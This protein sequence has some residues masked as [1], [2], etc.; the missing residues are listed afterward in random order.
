MLAAARA[1]HGAGARFAVAAGDAE[2]MP[3][4]AGSVDLILANLLLPWCR[5]DRVFAEVARVLAPNGLLLFATLGPDTLAEVRRAWAAVDDRIHVH[6]LFEMHDLGDLLVAA[7]L[8]EPVVD[9]DRLA[10]TYAT[11]AALVADLRA[12]GAVNV[13]AGRRRTL[14]GKRRW[15]GFEAALDADRGAERLAV[16]V[17]LIL[18]QAWRG[19]DRARTGDASGEVRIPADRVTRRSR[20]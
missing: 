19:A 13:A 6:A 4:A 7:G 16:G 20:R 11:V 10:V 14:T 3:A 9:V 17:E 2:R 18:G 15:R 8:E 12:C 5:P 1:R